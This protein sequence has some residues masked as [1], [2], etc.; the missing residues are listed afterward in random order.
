MAQ[1]LV[2]R[3]ICKPIQQGLYLLL[4]MVLYGGACIGGG[5]GSYYLL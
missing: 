1:V 5:S 4:G 3:S 2:P